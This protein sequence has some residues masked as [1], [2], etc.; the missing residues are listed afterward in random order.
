MDD[1]PV[2]KG[3]SALLQLHLT[4]QH[5]KVPEQIV[6]R[7]DMT[8]QRVQA[9]LTILHQLIVDAPHLVIPGQDRNLQELKKPYSVD[10]RAREAV[11][12]GRG[13][14]RTRGDMRG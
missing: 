1:E 8:F 5:C 2:C 10:G 11:R 12:R 7:G 13:G 9:R 3:S 4:T 6:P 14:R